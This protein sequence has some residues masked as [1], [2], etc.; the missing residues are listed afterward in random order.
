MHHLTFI[1]H[2][3]YAQAFVDYLK[4]L[5]VTDEAHYGADGAI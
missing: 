2:P 1:R 4:S 5:V 3:R